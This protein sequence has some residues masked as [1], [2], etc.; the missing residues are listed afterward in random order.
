MNPRPLAHRPSPPIIAN[1]GS[2]LGASL[3]NGL[4]S[5]VPHSRNGSH[6]IIGAAL[7]SGHRVSRRKSMTIPGTTNVAAVAAILQE[8]DALAHGAHR[9]A[10]SKVGGNVVSSSLGG[11]PRGT[12]AMAAALAV[13]GS[14]GRTGSLPLP[15]PPASLPTRKFLTADS[16][17]IDDDL[18]DMSDG[19]LEPASLSDASAI[20][21][22]LARARLASDG[23]SLLKEGRRSSRMEL[24]CKQC[25]KGYKHSS[26]LTKHLW[27]HTPEWALTSKLLI[28]KHQQ[29][30]LLEAA[31][32]LVNMNVNLSD[33]ELDA[34]AA[35]TPP[36]STRDSASDDD[37]VSPPPTF[38]SQHEI[39]SS[40]DTTP[41]PSSESI[42]NIGNAKVENLAL[43]PSSPQAP[44]PGFNSFSQRVSQAA[45]AAS[46]AYPY[47]A[48]F[49]AGRDATGFGND[50]RRRSSSGKNATGQEDRELAAAVELLSCSFNSGAGEANTVTS[51]SLRGLGHSA[52]PLGDT[53]FINSFPSRAPE[54]FTR[55]DHRR[56]SI[57]DDV[58]MDGS[59]DSIMDDEDDIQS[60]ARSDDD[61]E[62]VFGR[63]EE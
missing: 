28:S 59:V 55:G 10:L 52:T 43:Y 37:S 50:N 60:R 40:V 17:A 27:E 36:D 33:A 57:A 63:M 56:P 14:I 54:S 6:S 45:G 1:G 9:N 31:S 25:G 35:V 19:D 48:S 61:D 32:V 24:R 12:S 30:Q 20:A 53:S 62:G 7:N 23:Q 22:E 11:L 21:L 2:P 29:V 42:M 46:S 13:S 8:A 47:Q 16:S 39:R 49:A 58:K 18:N 34:N 3:S 38:A 5:R 51:N 4:P 15:S 44:A 41:P 26:C